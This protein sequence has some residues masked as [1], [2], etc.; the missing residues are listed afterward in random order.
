MELVEITKANWKKA[1]FLTT[2]S[3]RRMPLDE[4]WILSNA[5]PF[6]RPT[7]TRIGTAACWWKGERLWALPSMATGGS[8]IGIFY[9]GI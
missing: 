7:M 3:E 2:D 8:G 1:V 5:F 9:A 6:S 4:G